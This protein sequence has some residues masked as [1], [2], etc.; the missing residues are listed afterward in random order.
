MRAGERLASEVVP[1]S[2]AVRGAAAGS[3]VALVTERRIIWPLKAGPASG[4]RGAAP[5]AGESW[6]PGAC[7]DAP[8]AVRS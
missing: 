4:W 8:G 6:A 2:C 3:R 5:R 1:R 7:P